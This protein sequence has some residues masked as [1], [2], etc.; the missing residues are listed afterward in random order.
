[1]A[2]LVKPMSYDVNGKVYTFEEIVELAKKSEHIRIPEDDVEFS[3]WTHLFEFGFP[4]EISYNEY[5]SG[6]EP[7]DEDDE[8]EEFDTHV[9]EIATVWFGDRERAIVEAPFD[10]ALYMVLQFAPEYFGFE[11]DS[12]IKVI[13][14]DVEVEYDP[15]IHVPAFP[16]AF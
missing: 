14:N 15:D 5:L 12:K 9:F 7:E 3:S 6:W 16:Q 13:N 1:M 11:K 4:D 2:T 10:Y 8:P